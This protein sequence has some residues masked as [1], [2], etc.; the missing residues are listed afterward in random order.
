MLFYDLVASK[1][2]STF[3]RWE[4]PHMIFEPTP[5][6]W[7]S[8]S[9]A[10]A[11]H[12]LASYSHFPFHLDEDDWPSVEHYY[13]AMQ[14]DDPQIR[15]AIR[16]AQHPKDAEAIAKK[17]K[18]KIRKD[19]DKIKVTVMIRATYTKCRSHETVASALLATGD[20]KLLET[21]Q[22]DYFWGCG[23]DLR[24]KNQYG[25]VLMAVRQRLREEQAG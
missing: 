12:P 1:L 18:R 17:N 2:H 14:F 21:S 16:T 10:D 24:G 15:E 7:I 11:N 5:Q 19:W 3:L 4:D 22:Y 8:I 6:D 9:R 20:E 25:E 23:R 13:Q